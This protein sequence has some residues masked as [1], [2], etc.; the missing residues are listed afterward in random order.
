MLHFKNETETQEGFEKA[1]SCYKKADK[2]ED[3]G[4][5][6]QYTDRAIRK[7]EEQVNEELERLALD[8]KE[9]LLPEEHFLE[10]KRGYRELLS[11][12]GA[13]RYIDSSENT[14]NH[15]KKFLESL[16]HVS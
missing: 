10:M 7:R 12:I 11:Q 3:V 6:R 15:S 2:S 1:A 8:V 4:I 5:I 16:S 13:N 14:Q 9:G